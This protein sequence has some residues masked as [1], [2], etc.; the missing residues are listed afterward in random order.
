MRIKEYCLVLMLLLFAGAMAYSQENRREFSVDFRVNNSVID[1][2]YGNNAVQLSEIVSFVKETEQDSASSIVKVFFCGSA[3][4]EGSYQ[5]NK[6]LAQDRLKA[7][8]AIVRSEVAI[9]DSIIIYDDSYISWESLF[10]AVKESDLAQ[11][12]TVLAIISQE[13]YFIIHSGD[14]I[15]DHRIVKLQKLEHG[16]VWRQLHS[17][18]FDRMRHSRVIFVTSKEEQIAP[19]EVDSIVAPVKEEM[20][21]ETKADSVVVVVEPQEEEVV[22]DWIGKFY[23][24]TNTLGLAIAIPNVGVEIDLAKYLSLSVPVY[25]SAWNYFTSTVKFR[26]LAVQPE[27]RF[28]FNEKNQNFF[29]GA[30]FGYAQYNLAI[31]GEYRYQDHDG[32]SPLLGGG[33]SLG[34]RMP[35]SKNNRWHVEFAIGAGVYNLHYDRFYNVDNGKL[36]DTYHK[37]YWGIDNAAINIS[38]NIDLKK[39]KEKE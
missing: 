26:T 14:H 13:P 30:H 16:V 6:Q 34:Y 17:L 18:Y 39:R 12:D 21:V 19:V 10:D 29:L 35:M 38:Y 36:V 1:R 9:P 11:K 5:L 37:I 15:I 3:S 24:K 22:D 4:P 28:W 31:E 25:Y 23:I 32:K 2:N 20:V 7:I 8:E 33:I 27:L